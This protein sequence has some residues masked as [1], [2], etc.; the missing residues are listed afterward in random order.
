VAFPLVGGRDVTEN[1]DECGA[2]Y[3]HLLLKSSMPVDEIG[4]REDVR[5]QDIGDILDRKDAPASE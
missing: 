2:V 5:L 1:L 4:G 3:A